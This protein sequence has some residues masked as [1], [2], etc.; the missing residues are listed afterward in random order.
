MQ[1]IK[2]FWSTTIG[3]VAIILGSLIFICVA[4]LIFGSLLPQPPQQETI[5]QE[6]IM[7]TAEADVWKIFTQ[8]ALAIPT[9]TFT[10]E[11]TQTPSLTPEPTLTF[12]ATVPPLFET[13]TNGFYLINVDIAP[14]VW[15][16][17][18][19][20]SSCYWA[21]T[22]ATGDILNNHFGM[23]G[24]TAYVDPSGFQVEFNGC[25]TWTFIQAP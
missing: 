23:A 3:K 5:S 22:T 7:Q 6:S 15:K 16:S 2:K 20:D 17:N 21:V 12:T 25:G 9:N 1:A 19:T 4:C 18:G 24:G 11:V 8:T 14:G 10:P 13:K